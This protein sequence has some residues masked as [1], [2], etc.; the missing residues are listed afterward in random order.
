MERK[1][2]CGDALHVEF[3]ALRPQ[4]LVFGLTVGAENHA[5]D[6]FPQSSGSDYTHTALTLLASEDFLHMPS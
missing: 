3:V 4:Y 1:L 2:A 5:L 6:L